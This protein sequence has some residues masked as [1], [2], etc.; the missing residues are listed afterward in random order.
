MKTITVGFCADYQHTNS[1]QKVISD[2][3]ITELFCHDPLFFIKTQ[4]QFLHLFQQLT[5]FRVTSL[6]IDGLSWHMNSLS[7]APVPSANNYTIMTPYCT[8][9]KGSVLKLSCMTSS[10]L[11]LPP[12]NPPSSRLLPLQTTANTSLT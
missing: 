12:P 10:L 3:A 4:F 2:H 5:A 6:S 7:P 9:L 8:T 1:L 11:E